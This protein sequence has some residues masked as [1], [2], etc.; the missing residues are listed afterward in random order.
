MVQANVRR[1]RKLVAA[2]HGRRARPPGPDTGRTTADTTTDEIQAKERFVAAAA[3]RVKPRLAWDLGTNDGAFARIVAPH[4]QYVVASDFD[5]ETVEHL[6]QALKAQGDTKILPLVVD[7]TDPSPARGWRGAERQTLE[8]RGRPD[9]TLSLALIHHLSITRNVPVAEVVDWLASLGGAHVLEFPLREDRWCRRCSTPSATTATPTT[10]SRTSSAAWLSASSSQP[11]RA[12]HPRALRSGGPGAVSA[13]AA[14]PAASEDPQRHWPPV[15]LMGVHIAALWT[16]AFV[17]PLFDLLG[18][19]AAFFVARDNTPGDILILAFGFTLVPPLIATAVLAIVSRVSRRAAR[20]LHLGIIAVLA[21]VLVLQVVKGLSSSSAV[22]FPLA[23][24][25]GAGLAVLYARSNGLRTFVSV[26]GVAPIVV[27]ALLLVFSPVGDL[28]FRSD[29][30]ARQA[31]AKVA[32]GA[33][34]TTPVVV[35]IFDELP[36]TSLM[37]ADK[38][39]DGE[40]FPN[41]ARLARS[42]TWY[43]NATS[44]ADGTYVAVPAILTGLRPK[45]QLPTSREYPRS[46]FSLVGRTYDIHASE[47]ITHV[48]PEALCD[49]S[50][51]ATRQRTRLEDSPTTSRSSRA[52]CC[53]RTTWPGGCRPSTATGRTSPRTPA[54]TGSPRPPRPRTSRRPA[55]GTA[56]GSRA[57]TCRP[58]GCARA[59]R[60]SRR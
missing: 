11:A 50:A 37:T 19:N 30:G 16:L 54:T 33:A 29:Q 27:L 57:A 20:A 41:F 31:P 36:T 56:S 32:S 47:P 6:Y 4:A 34:P 51:T 21:A 7:L 1:M 10:T 26:L 60:S 49:T 18:K 52:G 35:L 46:L 44:V 9:L 39:I 58:G 15:W 38:R 55:A 17:Q 48:C 53:S 14:A 43:Q 3:E 28:V 2:S 22:L 5:H 45:A 13:A 8:Q 12:R 40:R 23:L 59:A 24:A 25:L 42:S